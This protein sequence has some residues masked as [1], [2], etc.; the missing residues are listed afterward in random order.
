MGGTLFTPTEGTPEES[1]TEGGKV[2]NVILRAPPAGCPEESPPPDFAN[3]VS[4]AP[5]S[6]SV[7]L[8]VGF[9]S[10]LSILMNPI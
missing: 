1:R 10:P 7:K 8:E 9:L 3:R 5:G 6:L 2:L 4:P